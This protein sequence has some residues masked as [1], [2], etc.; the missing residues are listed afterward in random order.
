M[1]EDVGL[2]GKPGAEMLEVNLFMLLSGFVI[3]FAWI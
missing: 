2:A 3:M 1:A